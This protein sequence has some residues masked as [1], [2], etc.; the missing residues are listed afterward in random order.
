[1]PPRPQIA[2]LT[3][4]KWGCVRCLAS[5]LQVLVEEGNRALPRQLRR[6]FVIA[7]RGVV[8][9]T[10]VNVRIHVRR[11]G[12]AIGFQGR[13]I[14]RPA[15]IGALIK[16]RI[17]QQ[18]RRLYVGN[19]LRFRLAPVIGYGGGQIGISN[20]HG[21]GD[22]ATVTET[23][24]TNFSGGRIMVTQ[25]LEGREEIFPQLTA[26]QFFLHIAANIVG[27]RI[28]AGRRQAFRSEGDEAGNGNATGNILD[29]GIEASILVHNDDSRQLP[30]GAPAG[31]TI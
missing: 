28:A 30:R 11:V 2:E 16:T 12:L 19:L 29:I 7:R 10:V 1:M 26:I 8:V 13:F 17:L 3:P 25:K 31:F 18:Q 14:S 5:P 6:R 23:D 20:G 15:V 4:P 21:I 27:A 22:A 9:E 24:D